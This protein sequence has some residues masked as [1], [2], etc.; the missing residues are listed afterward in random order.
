M[1]ILGFESLMDQ[2]NSVQVMEADPLPQD[3]GTEGKRGWSRQLLRKCSR[4]SDDEAEEGAYL[5]TALA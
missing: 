3:H 1:Y 4:E 2:N 5:M